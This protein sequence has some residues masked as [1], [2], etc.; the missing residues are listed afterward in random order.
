MNKQQKILIGVLGVS[1]TAFAVDYVQRTASAPDSTAV[2]QVESPASELAPTAAGVTPVATQKP[3]A[4]SVSQLLRDVDRVRGLSQEVADGFAPLSLP[5]QSA[6]AEKNTFASTHRMTATF[7]NGDASSVIVNGQFVR[8]GQSLGH[9]KLV[10]VQRKSAVFESDN[11][12]LTLT[13]AE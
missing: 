11:E 1:V 7:L 5:V 3:A 9:Y 12:S 2:A 4:K 8:L 6:K 13:L 10:T